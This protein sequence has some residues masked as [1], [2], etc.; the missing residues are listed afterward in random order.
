[1]S[2]DFGNFLSALVD[3]F[4][5]DDKQP[6]D[7]SSNRLLQ[8]IPD[9]LTDLNEFN[10][11]VTFQMEKLM[12][13]LIKKVN[14]KAKDVPYLLQLYQHYQFFDSHFEMLI[15]KHEGIACCAD[16]STMILR[17]V[18]NFL[19]SGVVIDFSNCHEFQKSLIFKDHETIM[20]FFYGLVSLRYG[21][22]EQYLHA[23]NVI[24]SKT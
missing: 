17:K 19:E 14:P 8:L 3:G 18:K 20:M 4:E 15:K 13:A 23:L 22:P 1:M 11:L 7:D 2:I 12:S 16:K 6:L 9:D 5:Q 10:I 21:Q 24:T